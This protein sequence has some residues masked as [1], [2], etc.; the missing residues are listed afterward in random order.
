MASFSRHDVVLVRYPYSDL[1]GAKVRPGVVVSAPHPS[2]DLR[3]SL[4]TSRTAGLMPG[5]FV[6]AEW[7]QSGLNVATAAKRGVYTIHQSLVAKRIGALRPADG[8]LL[9]QALGAWLGI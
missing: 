2:Q 8:Q 9:D 7:R 3:V 5:E 1:T 6:L 4:L